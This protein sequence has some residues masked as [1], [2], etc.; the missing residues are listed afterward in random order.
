MAEEEEREAAVLPGAKACRSQESAT[1]SPSQSHNSGITGQ[2]A[3]SITPMEGVGKLEHLEKEYMRLPFNTATYPHFFCLLLLK[4]HPKVS[5][6]PRRE[7][8]LT[9]PAK[10]EVNLP[11]HLY[12]VSLFVLFFNLS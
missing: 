2:N 1:N 7:E 11:C 12:S 5:S 8:S 6:L 10:G 3:K 9:S 4:F